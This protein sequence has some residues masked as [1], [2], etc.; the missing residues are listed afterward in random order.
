M[1]GWNYR[2]WLTTS[3]IKKD[4]PDLWYELL[5]DQLVFSYADQTGLWYDWNP[6]FA[7]LPEGRAQ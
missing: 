5:R 1:A 4:D 3:D 2:L 7:E 6:L